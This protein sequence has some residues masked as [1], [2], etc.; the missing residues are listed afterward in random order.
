MPSAQSENDAAR[1][2]PGSSLLMPPDAPAH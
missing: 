1:E 2:N